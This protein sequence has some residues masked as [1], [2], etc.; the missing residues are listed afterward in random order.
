MK[1]LEFKFKYEFSSKLEKHLFKNWVG[2]MFR[3]NCSEK[4]EWKEKPYKNLFRYSRKNWD[5]LI[6]Q[7]ESNIRDLSLQN[8]EIT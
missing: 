2:E 4:R 8:A 5:F 6:Y 1:Q 7:W 3:D